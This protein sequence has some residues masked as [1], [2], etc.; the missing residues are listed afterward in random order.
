MKKDLDY[1]VENYLLEQWINLSAGIARE[2]FY[3]KWCLPS[4]KDEKLMIYFFLG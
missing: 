1:K 4:Q 3:E 2:T